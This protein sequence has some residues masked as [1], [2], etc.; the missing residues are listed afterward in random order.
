MLADEKYISLQAEKITTFEE[1][2]LIIGENNIKLSFEDITVEAQEIKINLE[3]GMLESWGELTLNYKTYLLKGENLKFNLNEKEGSLN[4]PSG[5]EENIFF[6]GEK[7]SFSPDKIYLKKGKFTT[8]NLPS[9][10]YHVRA[11]EI[12][13]YPGEK[14]VVKN[15]TFY[16]GSIAIFWMPRYV[17]YLKQKESWR[18]LP[19]I[20]YSR[21]KGFYARIGYVFSPFRESWG[22]FKINYFEKKGIGGEVNLDYLSG[23]KDAKVKVFYLKEKDT[24]K[25]RSAGILRY[26]GFISTNS[27]LKININSLSDENVIEDYLNELSSEEKQIFPSYIALTSANDKAAF[28]F[29]IQKKVNSF[30]KTFEFLPRIG[31]NLK[32]SFLSQKLY[33]RENLE[34]TNFQTEEGETKRIFSSFNLSYP[35]TLFNFY[36]FKPAFEWDFFLY[37]P[38]KDSF[39]S[40]ALHH[41][42][43]EIFFSLEGKS[44]NMLHRLDTTLGYYFS[45][46]KGAE[47]ARELDFRETQRKEENALLLKIENKFKYKNLSFLQLDFKTGY[48]FLREERKFKPLEMSLLFSS[49]KNRFYADLSYDFQEKVFSYLHLGGEIERKNFS[50]S[51]DYTYRLEKGEFILS[52]FSFKPLRNVDMLLFGELGYN[53]ATH[54]MEKS[55]Y[56]INIKLHCLGLIVEIKDKPYYK[57][58]GSLYI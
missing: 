56:G 29:Q 47:F 48:S 44:K 35:F 40:N 22:E 26:K 1:P 46:K 21:E 25:E 49:E 24:R 5:K 18:V 3:T 7:A 58:G 2:P 20:G 8:C 14:I 4:Y 42:R 32:H 54:K 11:K 12:E 52:S 50:M 19:E 28:L 16:V 55:G 33:L 43:Y 27:L 6:K 57:L 10:H 37:D 36:R 38:E 39:R 23:K 34:L 9:P 15:A 13:I 41:Q 45:E 30:E 31:L 51:L 17:Y 53:L